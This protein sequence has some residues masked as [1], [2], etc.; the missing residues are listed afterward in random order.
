MPDTA[1]GRLQPSPSLSLG[2]HF[3]GRGTHFGVFSEQAERIELCLFDAAGRYETRLAMP[4]CTN[5]VWH[6]Y[7]RGARPGTLYGYRAQIGR[8]HV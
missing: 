4:E 7:L 3:D 2:A 6:G 8:A 5:G 1:A